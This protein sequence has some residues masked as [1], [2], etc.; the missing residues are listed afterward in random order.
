M[1]TENPLADC[2]L[3]TKRLSKPVTIVQFVNLMSKFI[4]EPQAHSAISDYLG[5]REIDGRGGVSEFELPNLK[6]FVEKTLAASLG[7]AWLPARASFSRM[8]WAA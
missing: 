2:I 7:G 1:L 4:G 3:E 6:R 8:V 5:E